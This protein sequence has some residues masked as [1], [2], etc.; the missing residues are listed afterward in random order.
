MSTCEITSE[1]CPK[2]RDGE[3]DPCACECP[4]GRYEWAFADP[5]SWFSPDDTC[6]HLSNNTPKHT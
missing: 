2:W 1:P 6:A 4:I 3:F 5:E